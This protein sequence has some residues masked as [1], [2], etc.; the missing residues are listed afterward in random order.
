M[1]RSVGW[2]ALILLVLASPARGGE[3]YEKLRNDYDGSLQAWY[4]SLQEA[5]AVGDASDPPDLPAH[6]AIRFVPRFRAFAKEQAG[7]PG[8]VP[9]LVWLIADGAKQAHN[10]E[11]AAAASW[12][13]DEL[14]QH[15]AAQPAIGEGLPNLIF[16]ESFVPVEKLKALHRQ[17][18]EKNKDAAAL[19]WATFSLGFIIHNEEQYAD[20]AAKSPARRA[21]ALKLFKKTVSKYEGTRAATWAACFVFELERLQIGMKAPEIVG[22]DADNRSIRLSDF[23][24]RV[25][26]IDFWGFW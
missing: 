22:T 7:K 19:S 23:M 1:K 18:M 5:A 14:I 15:H 10:E 13:L 6:P 11:S 24:G 17:V 12:A 20:E 2:L 26:V 3:D 9:A 21:K 16:A 4:A 25:V 8:A